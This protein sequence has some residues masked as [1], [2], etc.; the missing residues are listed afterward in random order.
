MLVSVFC[1]FISCG[2]GEFWVD[3]T[4]PREEALRIGERG[5][6]CRI[7]VATLGRVSLRV[8]SEISS[9]S[10]AAACALLTQMYAM[11]NR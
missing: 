4:Y 10:Q 1:V 9:V 8:C 7:L 3:L 5:S 2:V 11:C 6:S